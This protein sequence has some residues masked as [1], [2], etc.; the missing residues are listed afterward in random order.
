MFCLPILLRTSRTLSYTYKEMKTI[1]LD[2]VDPAKQT[3]GARLTKSRRNL[4]LAK[5]A[6]TAA[7]TK[8]LS[9][10][11]SP[12][13]IDPVK[14]TA[15]EEKEEW[16]EESR[17]RRRDY[18]EQR[19]MLTK[20]VSREEQMKEYVRLQ[21]INESKIAAFMALRA[22]QA[23]GLSA[24][25]L[26]Q[27][28]PHLLDPL[29]FDSPNVCALEIPCA[30]SRF[31][32]RALATMMHHISRQDILK[33]RLVSQACY[34]YTFDRSVEAWI[35]TGGL[36]PIFGLGY[37][38]LPVTRTS[39]VLRPATELLVE[40]PK[41]LNKRFAEKA[42]RIRGKNEGEM[43]FESVL[44]RSSKDTLVALPLRVG[45]SAFG[46]KGEHSSS[47]NL[48]VDHSTGVT[49]PNKDEML[50]G[51]GGSDMGG[52]LAF[53]FPSEQLTIS[54]LVNDQMSGSMVSRKVLDLVLHAFNLSVNDAYTG[55]KT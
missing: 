37:Q 3:V 31:T 52:N 24:L 6:D 39:S 12:S 7:Q 13:T 43:A 2:A 42:L 36:P 53:S 20:F 9:S 18:P 54:I 38:L 46:K 4:G 30:N 28:R 22:K 19:V 1:D 27:S 48:R 32:A 51:F 40:S 23:E 35:G 11:P 21:E 47:A 34:P 25:E 15:E 17:S 16:L 49:L 10:L 26:M 55:P 45:S 41:P 8:P 44:G 5:L 14:V 50:Y 29:L 33:P